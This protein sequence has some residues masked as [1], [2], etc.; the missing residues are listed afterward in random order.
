MFARFLFGAALAGATMLGGC[1]QLRAPDKPIE[2]N[3][4]INIKKEV[5]IKLAK[6][7]ADVIKKNPA[8]F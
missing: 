2:I 6:D 7:V 5:V 1:I 4:N 8:V 3:L